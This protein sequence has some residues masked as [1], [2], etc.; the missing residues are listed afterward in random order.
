MN[1]RGLVSVSGKPGL[2]KLIG[3]N[4]SG[5]ILETLDE[6]KNK[7]VVNISTAKMASLEDI[8][9]FGNSSDIKLSDIFQKMKDAKS[10]PDAKTADGKV[11]RSFFIE[12]APDHDQERVYASDMKKIISWFNLIKELPLFTEA[13]PEPLTE[14]GAPAIAEPVAKKPEPI[15]KEKPKATKAPAKS[16]TRVSQKSK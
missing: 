10:I 15:A 7:I 1:L 9:V 3:Q 14:G 4:K 13:A 2:F 11:L 16:A 12:V 5:F 6:L 8:T